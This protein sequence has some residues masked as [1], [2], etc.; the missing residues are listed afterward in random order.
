[1]RRDKQSEQQE[2]SNLRQPRK[3]FRAI[4]DRAVGFDVVYP[5]DH[6]HNIDG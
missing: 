2:Q 6:T 3:G 1:M 5:N 4:C